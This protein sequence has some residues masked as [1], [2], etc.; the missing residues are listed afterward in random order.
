[1]MGN[2]DEQMES[3]ASDVH[4]PD[5]SSEPAG[6][7]RS[8]T[9]RSAMRGRLFKLFFAVTVGTLIGVATA[10]FLASKLK[11]APLA[12][13]QGLLWPDPKVV[14]PFALVD[15]RGAPFTLEQL[16]GRWSFVFFGY[17]NCPDVSPLT[18]SMLDK[19]AGELGKE[20]VSNRDVQFVFV[21]VDPVRDTPEVLGKYLGNFN[22]N[23]IG[24]TGTD[25]MLTSLTR[26]LGI[27][28]VRE[29]PDADGNYAV[30]HGTAI[31]LIEPAGRLLGVFQAPRGALDVAERFRQ[32]RRFVTS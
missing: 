20:P 12:D 28:V 7:S 32:M 22:P 2:C 26:Q 21:S 1:M 15:H 19:V 27:Y 11:E 29:T 25:E 23:F 5:G 8:A 16:K 17:T 31:L 6:Q 24:V 3:D 4:A 10:E 9:R 13:V 18:L 30:D 14:Q